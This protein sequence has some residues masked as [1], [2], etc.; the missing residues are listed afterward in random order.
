MISR[1]AALLLVSLLAVPA[2][3]RA[4]RVGAEAHHALAQ[5][6]LAA[7]EREQ[8]EASLRKAV[9]EDATFL[10]ARLALG[11]ALLAR[12]QVTEGL[13]EVRA[14]AALTTDAAA[15]AA[16]PT[17]AARA[18][19]RAQ[20]LEATATALA[21]RV[22]KHVADCLALAAK[23]AEKDPDL[24]RGLWERVLR[25][26]PE[27]AEAKAKVAVPEE[28]GGKI[29][30]HFQ[31]AYGY[32]TYGLQGGLEVKDGVVSVTAGS[33]ASG[34]WA[35]AGVPSP[36]YDWRGEVR[37][38]KATGKPTVGLMVLYGKGDFSSIG[39]EDGRIFWDEYQNDKHALAFAKDPKSAGVTVDLS[40]WTRFEIRFRGEKAEA[41]VNGKRV[42]EL[43]RRNP[44]N[45]GTPGIHLT[46]CRA[47]FRNLSVREL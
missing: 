6:A 47:E 23:W 4:D 20:E 27:N 14:A 15:V 3:A 22:D 44:K 46:Q 16:W 21:A 19:K 25:L 11:E 26:R 38:L 8:A 1:T 9:A 31:S 10:P 36:D 43:P 37:I 30:P 28:P 17:E 33:V 2:G 41:W 5:K 29:T 7:G 45:V 13:A 42:A 35:L 12:G 24:A 34:A 39:I 40:T 18:K 32:D